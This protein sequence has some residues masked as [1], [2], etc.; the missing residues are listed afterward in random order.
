MDK[1]D[2][3]FEY[4]ALKSIPLVFALRDE[5]ITAE[6]CAAIQCQTVGDLLKVD[7]G[8]LDSGERSIDIELSRLRWKML[9]FPEMAEHALNGNWRGFSTFVQCRPEVMPEA[10]EW[11]YEDM[12][13]EYRREF[14]IGCYTHV[15]DSIE[16]CRNA[17]AE[18]LPGAEYELPDEYR[19]MN[20]LIVYRGGAEDIEDT[21][22][23]ISWS[24][25][26]SV[27]RFFQTRFIWQN[28][29][30]YR[31]K[32]KPRDVIAYTDERGEREVIQYASVY[33]VETIE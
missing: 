27:A 14:V 3:N 16:A 24:L 12:P 25:D 33:D 17:V 22:K 19:N 13:D 26:E 7:Y 28:R 29:K 31:G 20:E 8:D 9:S 21:D 18:L 4:E 32:I 10:F 30:L 23:C 6:Q 5:G 2:F 15:G 11:F 1:D